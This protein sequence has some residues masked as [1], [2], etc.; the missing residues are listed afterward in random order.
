MRAAHKPE[1]KSV[2]IIS[3]GDIQVLENQINEYKNE[4]YKIVTHTSVVRKTLMGAHEIIHT[5]VLG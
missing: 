2:K 5:F 1:S 3:S 4:G